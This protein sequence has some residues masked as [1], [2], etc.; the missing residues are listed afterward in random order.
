[1]FSNPTSVFPE[2]IAEFY[3]RISRFEEYGTDVEIELDLLNEALIAQDELLISDNP[4]P[5]N[6]RPFFFGLTVDWL[7]TDGKN[8][9][10]Q[11]NDNEW[12][13]LKVMPY[14][15]DEEIREPLGVVTITYSA[16]PIESKLYV[17]LA[18]GGKPTRSIPE[19]LIPKEAYITRHDLSFF[20]IYKTFKNFDNIKKMHILHVGQGHQ[21]RLFVNS[22]NYFCFDIGFSKSAQS[23]K[24]LKSKKLNYSGLKAVILSHWDSDHILGAFNSLG[25]DPINVPWLGPNIL[26]SQNSKRLALTI[27]RKDCKNLA[28]IDSNNCDCIIQ[29]SNLCMF[30]THSN[31]TNSVNDN[32][33]GIFIGDPNACILSIGDADYATIPECIS[34]R[35]NS[36]LDFLIVSHHGAEV[37]NKPPAPILSKNSKAIIPVGKNTFEHPRTIILKALKEMQYNVHRTDHD[38]PISIGIN[39]KTRNLKNINIRKQKQKSA[40]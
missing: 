37:K 2:R 13:C 21:S 22:K 17:I 27:F 1:M 29:L 5:P 31:D 16:S 26:N 25:S 4:L 20:N 40:S 34:R 36:G 32:G 14:N 15:S 8:Q 10:F 6:Y 9:L 19:I 23:D 24:T 39:K 35:A 28:L 38:G 12:H 11:I 18:I 3:G 7:S 33:I 30:T